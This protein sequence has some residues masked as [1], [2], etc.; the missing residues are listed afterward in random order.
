MIG[1]TDLEHPAL[2]LVRSG[3]D[4]VVAHLT[5][6]RPE[7]HNAFDASLIAQL[8]T[9]FS[10]LANEPPERLRV[11]VLAGDGPSFC[12]GADIAWMRAALELE[13]EANEQDAMAMAEMFEAID[14]CPV[15]V[16]ARVHGAALGGGTGLCAV[17]DLV[18]AESGTRFGFTETRLGILPAVISPFVIAKIGE[19]QA[20]A[21]FPRRST[22]RCGPGPADRPGP[23]AG[24]RRRCP[25]RG[26]GWRDR[27]CPGR[28]SDGSAGRQGDRARGPRPA[29]RVVEMAHGPGDCPTAPHSPRP[30]RASGHLPRSGRRAGR[31]RAASSSGREEIESP[32]RCSLP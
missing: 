25:R 2:R 7:R 6:A 8:R 3:P 30:R 4:G 32:R 9:A 29:P 23:R 28:R 24:R 27:R 13:T 5:L 15:P 10:G 21:L 1:M 31:I 17:S 22:L 16:I 11:V 12:A 14:T 20:R 26:R 18:I 19:S